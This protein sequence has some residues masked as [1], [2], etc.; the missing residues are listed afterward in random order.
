[1]PVATYTPNNTVDPTLPDFLQPIGGLVCRLSGAVTPF[2]QAQLRA[3][4]PT[5]GRFWRPYLRRLNRLIE[6][7]FLLPEDAAKL[8]ARIPATVSGW[9]D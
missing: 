7:R 6:R 9:L 5:H 2:S 3:L 8:R 4:Y 1:M